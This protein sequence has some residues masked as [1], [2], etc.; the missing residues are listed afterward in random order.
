M[1]KLIILNTKWFEHKFKPFRVISIL[2]FCL[3][4]LLLGQF[5]GGQGEGTD[6]RTTI[7]LDLEG[8]PSGI[9][10]LYAGGS[11]DGASSGST[12]GSFA[13]TPPTAL[14]SGG[15]GDGY[16]RSSSSSTLTGLNLTSLYTGGNGDGYS[17]LQQSQTLGGQ[18][19][20]ALYSGGGGDGEDHLLT[21]ATL[22]GHLLT[23]WYGGGNG[24]GFDHQLSS[25]SL[26]ALLML[27][28][29]GPGDGFDQQATN[30]LL[31]GVD[32]SLLYGGGTGD[33]AAITKFEGLVPLPLTLISFDAFP[34]DNYVLLRWV[35]EDEVDTDF[36]TIEKTKWGRDFEWVGETM[37]AG[38]SEPGEQLHY[39]LKDHSPYNGTSYYRLKTT[40]FDEYVS[41]SHLVEVNYS[42]EQDWGF[43]LFPNPN[44]GQHFNVQTNGITEEQLLTL[45]IFD[46]SGRLIEKKQYH[47]ADHSPRSFQLDQK[48]AAGSYLI[49]LI[50]PDQGQQ[51]KI[52]LVGGR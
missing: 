21:S 24:D 34:K 17:F 10:G 47:A 28:G 14:Y 15:S 45:E 5:S 31:S 33:G 29:G 19:L 27:Y 44:T 16:H 43:Q 51:A 18:D 50:H 37:A 26:G 11:D 20:S 4:Q 36:F 13:N 32:L 25:G 42:D 6:Q 2:F 52:L 3:P 41:L 38:F 39:E 12:F 9:R 7:Q 22:D 35:T 8:V 23:A 46:I 1:K 49:R 40:D 48:L 30:Q